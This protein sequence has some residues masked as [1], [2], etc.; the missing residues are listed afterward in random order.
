MTQNF[1]CRGE[2][3]DAAQMAKRSRVHHSGGVTVN[4]LSCHAHRLCFYRKNNR[5]GWKCQH[6]KQRID[7]GANINY[8]SLINQGGANDAQ[9]LQ[10]NDGAGGLGNSAEGMARVQPADGTEYEG[11]K[12]P[13]GMAVGFGVFRIKIGRAHV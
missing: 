13:G 9:R 12:Q 6:R 7:N 1:G 4:R 11:R 10:P 5:C 2:G 8:D 3:I